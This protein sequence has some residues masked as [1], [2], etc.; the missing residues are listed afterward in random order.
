MPA[1]NGAQL[2]IALLVIT[3][4][5]AVVRYI[6]DRVTVLCRGHV[7]ERGPTEQ[8]W[9][10]PGDQYTRRLLAAVPRFAKEVS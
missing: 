2:G 10:H 8:V 1:R 6:C 3:H 9:T 7:V 5:L 4:D